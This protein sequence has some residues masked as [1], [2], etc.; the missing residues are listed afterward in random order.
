MKKWPENRCEGAKMTPKEPAILYDL[1]KKGRI[2]CGKSRYVVSFGQE[3]V[4]R[5][6]SGIMTDGGTEA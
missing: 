2:A 6:L 3:D 1:L 5:V 4:G